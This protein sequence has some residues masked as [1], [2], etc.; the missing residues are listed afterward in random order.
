MGRYMGARWP[1]GWK[2]AKGKLKTASKGQKGEEAREGFPPR[3]PR[4][5]RQDISRCEATQFVVLSHSNP[6]KPPVPHSQSF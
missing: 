1:R 3:D 6:G 5:V 2:D 4:A